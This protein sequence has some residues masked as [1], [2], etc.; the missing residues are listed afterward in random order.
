MVQDMSMNEAAGTSTVVDDA[1]RARLIQTVRDWGYFD[2]VFANKRPLLEGRRLLDVGMGGG[3]FSIPAIETAGCASYVGVDPKVGTSSVLD[4]RSETDKSVPP[5]HAFPHSPQEIMRI[6]PNIRLF[7]DVLENVKDEVRSFGADMAYMSSV[8]EHLEHLP[9]VFETIWDSLEP[10][11]RLWFNH[12][13]YHSWTGHHAHPRD[14]RQWDRANPAHNRVVDWQHL[15]PAHPSY[16]DANFNRVRL[17]D[18]RRLVDKYF[19]V[20]EWRYS[21]DAQERLTP[22]IRARYRKYTLEELLGRTVNVLAV[23]RDVKLDTDLSDTP[24]HHPPESYLA[25]IDHS[26]DSLEGKYIYGSV[27]FAAGNRI[28]AHSTNNHAARLLFARLSVGDRLRLRKYFMVHEFTVS[29]VQPVG[30]GDFL[31]SFVESLP[32]DI[33]A[34]DRTEWSVDAAMSW[35]SFTS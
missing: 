25:D 4:L 31:V 11:S 15:D 28:A 23:R 22:E 10:G 26:G 34:S 21:F 6:Y 20:L 2:S 17:A 5:Y 19:H 18:L 9:E 32:D 30:D 16:K 12:H 13:G 27:F 29:A 33:L 35:H 7:G 3:P 1:E 14:V 24:F 8:T